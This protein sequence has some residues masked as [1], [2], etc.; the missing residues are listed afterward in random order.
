MSTETTTPSVQTEDLLSV[1]G[2]SS[3]YGDLTAVWDVSFRVAPGQVTLVVGRN[4]AGKTTTLMTVAGLLPPF[5]GELVFGGE[6][7]NSLSVRERVRRGI[8]FVP[9]GKRVFHALSVEDNLQV[10]GVMLPKAE[11]ARHLERVYDRF[12]LL[13]EFRSRRAGSLSGGQQQVLALGQALMGETRLL[14]LDEPSAGLAP[15]IFQD[16]I[17]AVRG[18]AREGVG[19]LLVEQVIDVAVPVAD[20]LVVIDRGRTVHDS[21]D[22]SGEAAQ[23]AISQHLHGPADIAV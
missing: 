22:P 14:V 9:E 8:S 13:A 23:S 2:L 20:R 15:K 3:G 19:V 1:R 17:E 5:G 4:G 12:P 16:V 21:T 10:G 7:L 11:R 18:L 6:D